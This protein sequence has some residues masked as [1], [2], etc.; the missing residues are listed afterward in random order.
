[1]KASSESGEWATVIVCVSMIVDI[2]A[3]RGIYNGLSD[4]SNEANRTWGVVARTS[5]LTA[6][7]DGV[8]DRI[9]FDGFETGVF[10]QVDQLSSRHL[11]FIIGLNRITLGKLAALGYGSVDIIRAI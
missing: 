6:S 11:N 9:A 8:I 1:M 10:D 5:W 4:K 2:T 3:S 7:P